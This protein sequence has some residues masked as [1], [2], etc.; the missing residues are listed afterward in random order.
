MKLFLNV[1]L[2]ILQKFLELF[3]KNNI[4]IELLLELVNIWIRTII[5]IVKI[6]QTVT[7]ISVPQ[8][9]IYFF[10]LSLS[11]T[12]VFLTYSSFMCTAACDVCSLIETVD[13]S[14]TTEGWEFQFPFHVPNQINIGHTSVYPYAMHPKVSLNIC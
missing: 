14:H 3:K 11:V 7:G 13:C 12:A 4:Y 1:F 5:F 8:L 9:H 10:G 6:S 2:R